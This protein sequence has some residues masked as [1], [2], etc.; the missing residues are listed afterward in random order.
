[1]TI[2]T[3]Q[4]SLCA[5]PP[6]YANCAGT[7]PDGGCARIAGLEAKLARYEQAAGELPEEPELFVETFGGGSHQGGIRDLRSID[8]ADTQRYVKKEKFDEE[9]DAA[10]A[11]KVKYKDAVDEQADDARKYDAW[12]LGLKVEN[13]SLRA[14]CG[15][16]Q[17]QG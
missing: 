4:C 8:G 5:C 16:R 3:N 10:V 7:T 6:P 12:L 1:M 9:R 11:L 13:E 15:L 2:S 17:I 14:T